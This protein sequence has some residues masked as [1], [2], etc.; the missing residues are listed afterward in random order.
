MQIKV[1]DNV[2]IGSILDALKIEGVKTGDIAKVIDGISEKPFRSALKVAGYEF[3]NKVPKGWHFV[4]VGDEPLEK[5]IFDYV[6][7]NIGVKRSSSKVRNV[8]QGEY[9]V[10]EGEQGMNM[11]AQLVHTRFS[12]KEINGILEML[13]EWQQRRKIADVIEVTDTIHDQIKTVPQADKVRK[14]IVIDKAI[15]E[16][17]DA[18]CEKE[19]VNKSDVMYL[20]LQVFLSK[21]G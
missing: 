19:R 13:N 2:T 18:F 20:A 7:S 17:L 14:T 6:P 21:N 1:D 9:K 5:S 11:D 12:Q 4:G 10:I 16:R 15:G 8:I 3:S